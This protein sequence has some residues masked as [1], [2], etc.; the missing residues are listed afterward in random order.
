MTVSEYFKGS[1]MEEG[2]IKT[3]EWKLQEDWI[4]DPFYS[5]N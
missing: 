4:H 5:F 2:G 1:H 3:K